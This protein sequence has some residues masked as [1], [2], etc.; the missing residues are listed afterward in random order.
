MSLGIG[1]IVKIVAVAGAVFRGHCQNVGRRVSFEGLR[2][3][4][5][6]QA[7]RTMEPTF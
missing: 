2:F 6:A 1:H 3:T 5:H 7:I 4:W